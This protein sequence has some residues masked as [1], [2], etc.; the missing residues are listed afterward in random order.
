MRSTSD[1]LGRPLNSQVSSHDTHLC[2]E[3][4]RY[5]ITIGLQRTVCLFTKKGTDETVP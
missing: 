1:S 4:I 5:D 2:Y 3:A